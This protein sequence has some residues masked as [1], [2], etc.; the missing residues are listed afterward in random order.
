[1]RSTLAIYLHREIRPVELGGVYEFKGYWNRS[2]KVSPIQHSCRFEHIDGC[3]LA[4]AGDGCHEG[5]IDHPQQYR[6]RFTSPIRSQFRSPVWYLEATC[7]SLLIDVDYTRKDYSGVLAESWEFQGKKWVFHLNKGIRF[8]DGTPLTAQDVT[9]SINRMK[10]DKKSLQQ[11]NFAD[12][13]ET[14]AV[15]D[16]TVV[17]TTEVPNAVFLDRLHNRFFAS[18]AAG[19]SMVIRWIKTRSEP[20]PTSW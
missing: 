4:S 20:D 15:D 2:E 17:I 10:N 8:H 9:Y 11:S 1:M 6:S 5:K 13:T 16:F 14:Q 12:V 19:E 7:S 18:K 3:V